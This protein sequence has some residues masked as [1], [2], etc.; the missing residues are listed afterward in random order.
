MVKVNYISSL[1]FLL[2]HSCLLLDTCQGDSGGPLMMFTKSQQWELVGITSYGEGCARPDFAGVYTRVAAYQS[3]IATTTNNAYANAVSSD[4]AN[5]IPSS[6]TNQ[7][8]S[9]VFHLSILLFVYILS[10]IM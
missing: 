9:S 2:S 7:L 6:G 5:I 1:F 3:W 8:S 4:Y 10:I